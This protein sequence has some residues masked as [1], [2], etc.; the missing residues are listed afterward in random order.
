[1]HLTA[2]LFWP[3]AVVHGIALST[4]DEPVLRG[5]TIAA[6]VAGAVAIGWRVFA[7]DP[8]TERR[9]AVAL[10]EWS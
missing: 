3:L 9:R 6:A 1:M 4:S 10:Q 7:T 5:L 2:F 8:D